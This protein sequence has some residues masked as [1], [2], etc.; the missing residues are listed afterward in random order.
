MVWMDGKKS[1]AFFSDTTGLSQSFF[2][3]GKQLNPHKST[4]S[5]IKAFQLKRMKEIDL[6]FQAAN[7]PSERNG[8]R[9]DFEDFL[10][11][12]KF[13][14]YIPLTINFVRQVD[15]LDSALIEALN[16]E[17]LADFKLVMLRCSWLYEDEYLCSKESSTEHLIETFE[18]AG[19][20]QDLQLIS[21]EVFLNIFLSFLAA[22]DVEIFANLK[23]KP[24]PLLLDLIPK[25]NFEIGAGKTILLP[26]RDAY[27]LPSRRLL[28]LT[29]AIFYH[30]KNDVWPEKPIGRQELSSLVGYEE[31]IGNFFDGTKKLSFDIYLNMCESLD[32]NVGNKS[33]ARPIPLFI[34][35]IFWRHIFVRLRKNYKIDSV[36][37]YDGGEYRKWWN[38]HHQ[39]WASQLQRGSKDW[40]TWLE[41]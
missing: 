31:V 40:P 32:N 8:H 28:E 36:I 14:P 25:A 18:Q 13:T 10:Y 29:H 4:L 5:K 6:S 33:G 20:F 12:L 11:G 21:N 19:S 22:L 39:K 26:K 24:R 35:A 38:F 17:S 27:R 41:N 23:L 2:R 37:L 30:A 3:K 7:I 9:S 34:A 1:S 15:K 16:R